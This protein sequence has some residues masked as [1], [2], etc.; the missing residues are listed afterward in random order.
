MSVTG[1][2]LAAGA[3]ERM[4]EPKL[5]LPYQES[6]VLNAT[7]AAVEASA[8]DRVIVVVGSNA[9]VIE[10][11]VE[12]H[13]S[14][15]VKNPDSSRGNMSSLMTAVSIDAD[16]EVFVVVPGDLPTIRTEAIDTLIDLWRE[17][18]PW[19]AVTEYVN[20]VAHPFLVSS[21]A[22]IVADES[23]GEK[24]LGRL[25]VD[26]ADDRVVRLAN[27]H[28]AP[29]DVNTP[30]DYKSLLQQTRPPFRGDRRTK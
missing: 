20:Q 27:S 9:D 30:A 21:A 4:G 1:V 18:H 6:T 22:V 16:A 14:T 8:V 10:R 24:V 29:L 26:S 17:T 5:L 15:V 12:A 23:E 19:A 13:R 7:I 3:S 28:N 25:L 2:V 11:S